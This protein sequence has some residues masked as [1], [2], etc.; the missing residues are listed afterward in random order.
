MTK[1]C[2]NIPRKLQKYD[3]V[4]HGEEWDRCLVSVIGDCRYCGPELASQFSEAYKVSFKAVC[5][6]RLTYFVLRRRDFTIVD[7]IEGS[8]AHDIPGLTRSGF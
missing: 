5:P 6:T 7:V 3:Q 2:K 4:S 1:A 8:E